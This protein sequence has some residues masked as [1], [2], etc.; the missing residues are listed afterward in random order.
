MIAIIESI[1]LNINQLLIKFLKFVEVCVVVALI[2]L[3]LLVG[4]QAPSRI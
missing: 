1:S 3:R 2:V 4:R